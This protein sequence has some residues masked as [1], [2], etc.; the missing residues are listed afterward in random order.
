MQN[1]AKGIKTY[2][3]KTFGFQDYEDCLIAVLPRF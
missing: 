3:A 2:K 1:R